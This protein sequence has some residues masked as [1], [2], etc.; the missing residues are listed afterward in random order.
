MVHLYTKTSSQEMLATA[1]F[2]VVLCGF[3]LAEF[4]HQVDAENAEVIVRDFAGL[5]YKRLVPVQPVGGRNETSLGDINNS[6]SQNLKAKSQKQT[7]SKSPKK[8]SKKNSKSKRKSKKR[9][10]K[11]RN[12]KKSKKR[13][14]KKQKGSKK[15]RGNKTKGEPS[16][17]VQM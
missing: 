3:V 6:I 8:K 9:K 15:N 5:R 14:E 4:S 2:L 10:D 17:T 7:K 11:K 13:K 1:S 12:K 16:Q